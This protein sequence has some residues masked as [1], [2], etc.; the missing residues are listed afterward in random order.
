MPD[1]SEVNGNDARYVSGRAAIV[2]VGN[3]E[4]GR[5]PEMSRWDL[6][7]DASIAAIED[8]G[9]AK[10]EIDGLL[11]CGSLI[12]PHARE[13]LR[14]ADQLGLAPR[15]FNDTT[16]MGGCS[17]A[18]AARYAACLIALGQASVVLVAGADNMFTGNREEYEKQ[19]SQ[20]ARSSA[21]RKMMS[22][23]DLEFIEPYGNIPAANFAMIA[24][25]HM[26]EFGWTREQIAAVSVAERNNARRT[27]GAVMT[28]PITVQDVLDAPVISDP[29]GRLDCPLISDGGG[30]FI[31]ASV[32]RARSLRHPP[33]Y[34]TG[35]GGVSSSY[36]T[37]GFPDLVDFPRWMIGKSAAAAY[38]MA[39]A[40]PK[41]MDIAAI[42]DPFSW[43]VPI[44]LEGAGFCGR[45]EGAGYVASGAIDRD[46]SLPVNTHGGQLSYTHPGNPGPL[47]HLLEITRQ[48]RGEEGERQVP[49]VETGFVHFFGGTMAQH[50][51]LVLSTSAS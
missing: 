41:D 8:S 18:A 22:I 3:S 17:A 30:A 33:V 28:K 6:L 20:A 21:V 26:H 36:Y 14:L 37:P 51:S 43:V 16:A 2:G 46:G 12:E 27:P 4:Q 29:F 42:V 32:D 1:N 31:V 38:T 15:S 25:R 35:I 39:K 5:L 48:L 13:H 40:G 23:H 9:V 44:I 7:I 10:D 11:C 34:V 50:T 47:F 19:G 49:G 45:G 24:R